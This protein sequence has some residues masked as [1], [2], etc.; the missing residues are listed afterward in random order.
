MSANIF[1][2]AHHVHRCLTCINLAP[3]RGGDTF[4]NRLLIGPFCTQIK[5]D[6]YCDG[7]F[8]LHLDSD[9]VL[10]EDITYDHIF[11]LEK[12]VLPFRRYRQEDDEDGEST[13]EVSFGGEFS[14]IM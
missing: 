6:T 9:T 1:L 13:I 8:I 3:A 11:H 4:D 14:D 2:R 12:P 10:F 7:E 5:A